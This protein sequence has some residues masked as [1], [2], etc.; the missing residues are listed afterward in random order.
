MGNAAGVI[1]YFVSPRKPPERYLERIRRKIPEFGRELRR[2]IERIAEL[3]RELEHVTVS[4]ETQR[5]VAIATMSA[6]M[7]GAM[8]GAAMVMSS[9]TARYGY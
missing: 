3:A 5:L 2:S 7:T 6:V 4:E 9:M 1:F 8:I